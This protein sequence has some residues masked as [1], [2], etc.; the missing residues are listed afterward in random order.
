MNLF[1]PA[2]MPFENYFFPGE[3]PSNFIF[4]IS[5]G[6]TSRSLMVVPILSEQG[7]G[8]GREKLLVFVLALCYYVEEKFLGITSCGYVVLD[9]RLQTFCR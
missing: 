6:P 2:V 1:F 5:S 8:L 3:E 4:S 7:H 9:L